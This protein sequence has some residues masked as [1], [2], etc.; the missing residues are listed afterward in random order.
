MGVSSDSA[1]IL[2]SGFLK[3]LVIFTDPGLEKGDNAFRKTVLASHGAL[4]V[5]LDPSTALLVRDDDAVV[6]GAGFVRFGRMDG[7]AVQIWE[8]SPGEH[9]NLASRK[10]EGRPAKGTGAVR[11]AVYS[12]AGTR[13]QNEAVIRSCLADEK[14]SFAVTAVGPEE[15]RGGRLGDFDVL[16]QSGGRASEQ[17]DALGEE[18]RER[19]REFVRRGGGYVGLNAGSYLSAA[20]RPYY[21]HLLNAKVID[22]EHWGRGKGNVR[23][24]FTEEGRRMLDHPLHTAQLQFTNCPLFVR[25]SQP[26]LPSYNELAIYETEISDGEAP[27][28]VM[29]GA[30]AMA[31]APYGKGRVFCSGPHPTAKNADWKEFLQRAVLWSAGRDPLPEQE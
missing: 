17:A 13:T 24:R 22:R 31:S 10:P 11:V 14:G 23:I 12:G 28:G 20:D 25:D 4:C 21:L 29:K 19:I 16:I 18:G 9:F 30:S 1:S 15:I 6:V 27:Q 5:D 26:D 8:L 2:A 3:G 7:G